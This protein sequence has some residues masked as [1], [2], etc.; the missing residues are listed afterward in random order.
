MDST[1]TYKVGIVGGCFP[2][3]H[4]VVH[5][6][7]FHQKLCAMIEQETGRCIDTHIERYEQLSKALSK[8]QRSLDSGCHSIIFQVRPDPYLRLSKLWYKF[9]DEQG[10]VRYTLNLP[11]LHHLPSEQQNYRISLQQATPTI[12]EPTGAL[13]AVLRELNYCAGVLTLGNISALRRYATLVVDIEKLCSEYGATLIIIGAG[14]R[15]RTPMEQ[16]LSWKLERYIRKSVQSIETIRYVNIWGTRSEQGENLY[17]EDGM[18]VRP[19]GHERV[20]KFLFPILLREIQ[21][22]SGT[23]QNNHNDFTTSTFSS[24][25]SDLL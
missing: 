24:I 22:V 13:H 23:M 18:H 10:R 1:A 20:A 2:A 16:Y 4:N 12:T 17:F 3:Q 5:K 14:S 19:I 25:N 11:Q 6:D 21:I 8:V 7:L 15:P 9:T